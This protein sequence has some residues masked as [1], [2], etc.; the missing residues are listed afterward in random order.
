[1]NDVLEKLGYCQLMIFSCFN[2]K[3]VGTKRF[4][5]V[6][7]GISFRKE[8]KAAHG[9]SIPSTLALPDIVLSFVESRNG[10]HQEMGKMRNPCN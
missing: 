5:F 1:M 2:F 9:G 8:C 4:L 6:E 10:M 3:V 7:C